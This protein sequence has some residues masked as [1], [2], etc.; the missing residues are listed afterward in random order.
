MAFPTEFLDELRRRITLSSLIARRVKLQ[1]RGQEHTGLCPFHKEKTPSFT[2]SDAKGFYHCFGCGA[3]GDVIGFVIETEG[4]AFPEAVAK[5]AGEAGLELPRQDPAERERDKRRDG[6]IEVLAA[7]AA[8]FQERLRDGAGA[9]ARD[10]LSG[11]GL[12]PATV[13]SFALGYAPPERGALRQALEKRG[14]TPQLMAEA[15]LIKLPEEGAGT[16]P[17]DYFFNRL[18]FP[19]TDRRGRVIAFGGRALGESKA[20]YINSPESPL[21][22]KG[23]VLYNHAGALRAVRDRGEL[24]VVEGY[25]DVIALAQAGFPGAVAPLGTAVT[26]EQIAELWRMLP[27]PILCLDGDSA[28]RRAAFRAAERAL[29]ALEPG[30][31]LRFAFL[32]EGEDPDSLILA[33]GSGA[34]R[35]TLDRAIGLVDLLWLKETEGRDFSTPERRAGLRRDLRRLVQG[36]TDRE[37]AADYLDELMARYERAFPRR[38]GGRRFERAGSTTSVRLGAAPANLGGVPVRLGVAPLSG[39]PDPERRM[40]RRCEQL[41]LAL[42][43]NHPWLLEEQAEAIATLDFRSKDLLPVLHEIIDA[44]VSRSSEPS[45]ASDSSRPILDSD[46][47]KCH[48]RAKGYAGV[49]EDLFSPDVMVHGKFARADASEE[50]ERQGLVHLKEGIRQRASRSDSENAARA[51]AENMTEEALERLRAHQELGAA[52]RPTE[53]R[54]EEFSAM[55]PGGHKQGRI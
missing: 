45:G 11:R 51:L 41:L 34:L 29:A 5:L 6:L 27:E 46:G 36:V 48:L 8:W 33:E 12:L 38:S 32:P 14:F 31:S 44:F 23:R 20:K 47:L 13:E 35:A 42:L 3:H 15:G 24:I 4:L 18:I 30:N 50:A 9:S 19:I 52:D 37:L 49:L 2:V 16:G 55:N 25:M 40:R 28:G 22:H 54:A 43:I 7:A 39:R 26:E 21:F 53:D 17:R 10:Y 1:R